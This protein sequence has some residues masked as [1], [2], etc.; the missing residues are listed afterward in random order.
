MAASFLEDGLVA[1]LNADS[2]VN[3]LLA[4]RVYPVQGPP[5]NPTYPYTTYQDITASSD[6]ALDGAETQTRRIQFDHWGMAYADGK[7]IAKAFR[8]VLSGFSGTLQD[9]TRVLFSKRLN[10]LDNFD[11]DTRSYRSISEFE[12]LISEA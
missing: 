1:L 2:G 9:G 8:N 5:D 6:Y 4:G 3:A 12:F 7:T 11:E 10:Y